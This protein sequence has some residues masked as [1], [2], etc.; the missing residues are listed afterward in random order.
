[1]V[2]TTENR[3]N[4]KELKDTRDYSKRKKDL[5]SSFTVM[6]LKHSLT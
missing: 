2:V 5:A 6:C 3:N 1:M 4:N